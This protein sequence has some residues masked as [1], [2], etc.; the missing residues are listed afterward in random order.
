MPLRDHFRPPISK[1]HSWEGFH[2][3]WPATMVQ[4]LVKQLPENYVAE[5]RVHL[6]DYFEI[7]VCTFEDDADADTLPTPINEGKSSVATVP[8]VAPAPSLSIE[9]EIPE[10][11]EYEVLVFDLERE[12]QLVAAVEIVSPANKDRPDSR[13]IFVA[14]CAALLRKGVCVSIVDVVTIRH[15]NLYTDLL[16]LL[17][18]SDPTFQPKPTSIYAVTCRKRKAGKR[19]QLDSWATP[20][21]IGQ[22][23]PILPIWLEETL[24]V[25]LDLESSYE[26][27]CH[28]LRIR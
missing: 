26:E 18:Q 16:A 14:K 13:Q 8:W 28:A 5:P 9:A 27:T 23:L 20:L 19:T 24:P 25:S 7:D 22:P 12:R 3:L 11:Y 4:N 1:R 21:V 15:F 6:G 10:Q 17:G 2:G